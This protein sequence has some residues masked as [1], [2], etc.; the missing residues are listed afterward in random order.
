MSKFSVETFMANLPD[1]ILRDEHLKQLAEVAARVL[2]KYGKNR[3]Q[4]AIYSRIDEL[5][6]SLLDILAEDLKVDWYDPS[7]SITVKRRIIKDN[8]YV[9]KRLGTAGAVEKAL[10]GVWPDSLVEEWF[11]YGGNPFYFRVVLTPSEDEPMD[12]DK[13]LRTIRMYK[14][15]RATLESGIPS[16][17]ILHSILIETDHE[18]HYYHVPVCGTT[19]RV[20]S[21]GASDDSGLVLGTSLG[22]AGYHVRRCGTSNTA[23]M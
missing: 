19:P 2:L 20:S 11:E 13:V 14:P 6:E 16:I 17:R 22:S 9:H 3:V 15:A 1:P 7:S 18:N 5:D 12:Y 23:L 8:W 4:A 10:S 21:H